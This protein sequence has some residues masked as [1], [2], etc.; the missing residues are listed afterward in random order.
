M[1]S[2]VAFFVKYPIWANALMVVLIIFGIF[3]YVLGLKRSFFPELDPGVVVI[4]TVL[5]GASPLEMEEG[6]T[7]KIEES[8][9]GVEGIDEVS[10]NSIENLSTV[11]VLLKKEYN[12][13]SV[14]TDVKNAV[15]K[16]N[17]F[18][19]NA[20][21]P[22]V[23]RQPQQ[24]RGV[25]MA[26]YGK[27]DRLTLRRFA[28]M[29][30]D[31]LLATGA[32]SSVVVS[33]LP[34]LEISIEVSDEALSRYGLT[35]RQIADIIRTSNRDIS[36]GTLK[37]QGEEILIRG[38]GQRKLADE[39]GDIVIRGATAGGAQ[40]K[41]RDV[42]AIK[43]QLA[44]EP[45]DIKVNGIEAVSIVVE[46]REGEDLEKV[47]NTTLNYIA[48]FNEKYPNLK[49]E[50][51]FNFKNLLDQRLEML[52]NNGAI[53]LILV[54]IC[55][56]MFLNLRVA[57]WVALGI[58]IS[59]AGML[60]MAMLM[61]LTINMISLFGM[62][63]V[64]G[65]LVDDGI[66]IAEN[67]FSHY[68]QGKS[69]EQA[70]ID[71]TIEVAGSVF[72][73]V[74]TT[75]V[76]FVPLLLLNSGGL[77]FM[78][79]MA[80]VVVLSLGISLL[81]AFFILPAHMAS[82]HVLNPEHRKTES[83]IRKFL[84]SF[85]NFL[86][87]RVYTP[88]LKHILLYRYLYLW[89]PVAFIF[90]VAGAFKGEL[91][92]GVFF[93]QIPFDSFNV[94]IA[95]KAGTRE[96]AVIDRLNEIEAKAWELEEELKAEFGDKEG[97]IA[98]VAKNLG[99]TNDNSE[100][101]THAG[102]INIILKDVD[103]KPI[104]SDEVS[105]RLRRK[106][107]EQPD[108][109]KFRVGGFN[110]FGKPISFSLFARDPRVLEAATQEF[111]S[112]LSEYS[113]LRDITD[114]AKLGRR[115][116]LLQINEKAKILGFT[117][118]EITSQ[119]RQAFFGE[120]AQRIQ[121]GNNELR[122]WVRLPDSD[123]A[124]LDNLDKLKIRRGNE[125][126]PLIE[127]A[128]YKIER[129][130]VD[131]KHY[132]GQRE[133]VIEAELADLSAPT[134]SIVA[135][136][137]S[138]ILADMLQ[139]YPGLSYGAGGQ[140]RNLQKTFKAASTTVPLALLIII[141]LI[142]LTFRSLPQAL[143]VMLML[144]I[145][146]YSAILGHGIVG[147]PFSILSVWGT[148]ALSGVII[149]DT[150]V[151]LDKFNQNLRKGL[152]FYDAVLNAGRSR[153]RAIILTSLTTVAGLYPLILEKSFQAQFLIPMA[154]SMA[155]GVLLGTFFTL[156]ILPTIIY[157]LNDLRRLFIWSVLAIKYLIWGSKTQLEMPLREEVE[158]T[159][160]EEKRLSVFHVE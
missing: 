160:R 98:F 51:L 125:E 148:L 107:G 138:T 152:P 16:I 141:L 41:L 34:P 81:E 5:P 134:P 124:T 103:K 154:I 1:K 68:E 22:I 158:P 62:I 47:V 86:R 87:D 45:N 60:T 112:R 29:I 133:I 93:P 7:N 159:V 108:L 109:E 83:P 110:R 43:E 101:G 3:S 105:Q 65:I 139:K 156:L 50:V 66:V 113:V 21:K 150:V 120:E 31:E 91:I 61:G 118:G 129:G 76:A 71:G 153:F 39:I 18:P 49:L 72:T 37:T 53:G 33:G 82:H 94:D 119:V 132:Q 151:F 14:L 63:L 131:I 74:L 144:P 11:R 84:D 67:I 104:S 73:S 75:I 88:A 79:E 12:P 96:Q 15:D 143:M 13:E 155:Y 135:N 122:V 145:G 70:A 123:K 130:L 8:L 127:L 126:Y 46:K 28:D 106:V 85:F 95:F 36:A 20:E 64:I 54:A 100:T 115:E 44:D 17:S 19:I 92:K 77:E 23:F 30:E 56:G 114:N 58:P 149:N 137:E 147:K 157:A 89:I 78:K 25:E 140:Q 48:Q 35:I 121:S 146:V 128:E 116:I 99:K 57:F 9:K 55:L 52:I 6:I 59:F 27:V 80:V 90:I 69:P 142:T 2:A 24:S 42:A 136:I 10:S 26:L 97:F 32:L 4:T 117:N 38:E 40:L 102:N 111:K